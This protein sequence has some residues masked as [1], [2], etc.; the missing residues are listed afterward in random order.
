MTL[1]F[2]KKKLIL[3]YENLGLKDLYIYFEDSLVN[4]SLFN[5]GDP[6]FYC[7]RFI[8]VFKDRKSK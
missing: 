6:S 3:I 5:Y 8:V 7:T 1:V 2:V 4:K